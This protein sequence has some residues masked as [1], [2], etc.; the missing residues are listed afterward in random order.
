MSNRNAFFTSSATGRTY[1]IDA[2]GIASEVTEQDENDHFD[3]DEM[4]RDAA[5]AE[6]EASGR[7]RYHAWDMG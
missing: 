4:R 2:N 7:D 5:Q 6:W 3:E 1:W